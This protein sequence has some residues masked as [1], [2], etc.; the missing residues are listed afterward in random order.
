LSPGAR[1]YLFHHVFLPPKLPQED[2][3]HAEHECTLLDT[4]ICALQGFKAYLPG[5]QDQIITSVITMLSH[6]REI[7][8]SCGD[9]TEKALKRA[10]ERLDSQGKPMSPSFNSAI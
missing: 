4:V 6:L 10:L 5:Q 9:V 8:G 1:Q 7:L 3:Y 2:D